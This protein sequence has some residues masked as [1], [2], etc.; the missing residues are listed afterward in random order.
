MV[1][2]VDTKPIFTLR[3]NEQITLM[4]ADAAPAIAVNA[5]DESILRLCSFS[6]EIQGGFNVYY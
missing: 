1:A 3:H 6:N 2:I 4:M 5:I